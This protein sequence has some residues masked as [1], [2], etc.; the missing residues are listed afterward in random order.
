MKGNILTKLFLVVENILIISELL[1]SEF[2]LYIA[3]Q[4]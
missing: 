4:N 2:E 1:K 3:K